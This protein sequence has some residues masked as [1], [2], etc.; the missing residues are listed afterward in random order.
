MEMEGEIDDIDD[1]NFLTAFSCLG[2]TDKDDLIKQF[3][4]IGDNLHHT[5]AQFFLEM[6]NW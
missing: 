5:T 6:N 3:Q 2:T 4:Q 1:Q